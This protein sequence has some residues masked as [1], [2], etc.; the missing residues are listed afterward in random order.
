MDL[1][2]SEGYEPLVVARRDEALHTLSECRDF[3]AILIDFDVEGNLDGID[4]AR[5]ILATHAL[6][7]LFYPH[8]LRPAAIASSREIRHGGVIPRNADPQLLLTNLKTALEETRT[9]AEE[10]LNVAAS[11]ILGLE[12]DGTIS[13]LND[14]AHQLLGYERGSLIGKNWFETCIPEHARE[15]VSQTL[16]DL[17]Q[18]GSRMEHVYENPVVTKDGEERII[19]WHNAVISKESDDSYALV[20]SGEDIT[21]R[22]R[23][24]QALRK[25]LGYEEAVTAAARVLAEPDGRLE[26]A[27]SPLLTATESSRVYVFANSF[28]GSGQ[29]CMSQIAEVCAAHVSRQ[30]DNPSLQ[31]LPYDRISPELRRRLEEGRAFDSRVC[32]LPEPDRRILEA[33][34]I[35][36]LLLIPIFGTGM[37]RGFIGFDQC[38]PDRSWPTEDIDLLESVAAM[39]GNTLARRHT[40]EELQSHLAFQ[41]VVSEVSARFVGAVGEETDSAIDFLLRRLATFFDADRGYVFRITPDAGTVS[42]THEWCAPGTEPQRQSLQDVPLESLAHLLSA[43]RSG[44]VLHVPDIA[45]LPESAARER[46]HLALH[47]VRAMLSVPIVTQGRVTGFLG[48]DL[49]HE[50]R[51]WTEEQIRL[52]K[53]MADIVAGASETR[54]AVQAFEEERNLMH[55]LLDTSPDYIFFKDTAGRFTRVSASLARALGLE[56]AESAVHSTSWDH[57][58]EARA[59]L[60]AEEEQEMLETG[61]AKIDTDQQITWPNGEKSWVSTTKVPLFATQG[62]PIGIFGIGRDVTE[63]KRAEEE[64]QQLLEEKDLVLQEVHHRIKNNMA[65]IQSLLSLQAQMMESESAREALEEA[66]SRLQ[67]M[68]VLYEKLYRSGNVTEMSMRDYLSS[69]TCEVVRLVQGETAVSVET[70]IDDVIL[71]VRTLSTLGLIVNELVTNSVKHAFPETQEGAVTLSVM[72][73]TARGQEGLHLTYHDNGVGIPDAV[74]AGESSGL[75]MVLVRNLTE[76]LEGTMTITREAGTAVQLFLPHVGVHL[77]KQKHAKGRSS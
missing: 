38:G 57:F 31:L 19:M 62:N 27:L 34:E 63:R 4:L 26:D 58:G 44:T 25:R 32:D 50:A 3:A 30:I 2:R 52:T 60:I 18:G 20:S 40:E 68:E 74:I 77:V 45:D 6:P 46:E 1:L 39:I 14:S 10:L 16:T 28:N 53:V 42:N 9:R 41:Q 7:L 59:K 70:N 33:Q 8:R 48:F 54:R 13:L 76:Q 36:H 5:D 66:R 11:I 75:G 23:M 35:G 67:S 43:L 61:A 29:L 56:S 15:E 65:S 51:A 64:V 72:C 71:P 55:L 37:W 22:K 69:L 49:I 73:E 17:M 12:S 24:E 47:G 21:E